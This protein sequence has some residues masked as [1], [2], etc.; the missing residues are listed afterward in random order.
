MLY[1]ILEKTPFSAQYF[2]SE[3]FRPI[4][5]FQLQEAEYNLKLNKTHYY[6]HAV[7][8][9]DRFW[10]PREIAERIAEY[11]RKKWSFAEYQLSEVE[12]T[13][14]NASTRTAGYGVQIF[15]PERIMACGHEEKYT[16]YSERRN[17]CAIC[18]EDAHAPGVPFSRPRR[19]L[20]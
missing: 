18:G 10:Y 14:N 16:V 17:Y 5:E 4:A 11:W 8:V 3:P 12:S 2:P 1:Q 7:K 20:R 15:D 6:E 19:R 13:P 9:G